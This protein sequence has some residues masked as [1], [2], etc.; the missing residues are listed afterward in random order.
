MEPEGADYYGERERE[1][2]QAVANEGAGADLFDGT[3]SASAIDAQAAMVG[4]EDC[5]HEPAKRQGCDY[6]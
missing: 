1:K 2:L 3:Y 5:D 6:R 4:G